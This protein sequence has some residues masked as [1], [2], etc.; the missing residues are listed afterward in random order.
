MDEGF[1]DWAASGGGGGE[2]VDADFGKIR[3]CDGGQ[4]VGAVVGEAIEGVAV[5]TDAFLFRKSRHGDAQSDAEPTFHEGGDGVELVDFNARFPWQPAAI[6]FLGEGVHQGFYLWQGNDGFGGEQF[7]PRFVRPFAWDDELQRKFGERLAID[8][9]HGGLAVGGD[10]DIE[11]AGHDGFGE[12][13][14]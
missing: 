1:D 11:V 3:Q 14:S 12:C 7:V 10:G 9:A 6:H 2:E 8:A 5:A 4:G 13:G